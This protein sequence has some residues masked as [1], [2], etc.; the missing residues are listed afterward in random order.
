MFIFLQLAMGTY[1][2]TWA[3]GICTLENEGVSPKCVACG[4]P[5]PWLSVEELST[6]SGAACAAARSPLRAL[7][8]GKSTD[9]RR[10][11]VQPPVQSPVVFR[12]GAVFRSVDEVILASGIDVDL[13][14]ELIAY[15][16]YWGGNPALL[17]AGGEEGGEKREGREE[18]GEGRE[19]REGREE[20]EEGGESVR[21]ARI[22]RSSGHSPWGESARPSTSIQ[23]YSF[24]I[25]GDLGASCV[26][27][28]RDRVAALVEHGPFMARLLEVVS[29]PAYVHRLNRLNRLFTGCF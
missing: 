24:A 27:C 14:V 23:D 2:P 22:V 19:G 8:V 11:F 10:A 18:G 7:R 21:A 28:T 12:S 25:L 13:F 1:L 4:S 6:P 3:C 5:A 20:G 16:C 26:A 9:V 17:E 29:D 15:G